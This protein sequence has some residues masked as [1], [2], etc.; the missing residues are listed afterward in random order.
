MRDICPL[1]EEGEPIV[2][3]KIEDCW[4]IGPFEESLPRYKMN[5]IINHLGKTESS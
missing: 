3:L 5:L 1:H 4:T 2:Y